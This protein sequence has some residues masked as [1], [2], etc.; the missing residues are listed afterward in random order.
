MSED[1]DANAVSSD[2]NGR[3]DQRQS[4][5]QERGTEVGAEAANR[6]QEDARRL[7]DRVDS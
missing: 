4:R 2:N 1:E 6:I 3:E 5:D 7:L